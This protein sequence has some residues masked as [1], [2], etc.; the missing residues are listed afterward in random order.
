MNTRSATEFHLSLVAWE[1][2][3][4]LTWSAKTLGGCKSREQQVWSFFRWWANSLEIPLVKLP[5]VL[6]WERGEIGERPHA[7]FLLT[8]TGRVNIGE[9]FYRMS[10]WGEA[11]GH[12]KVRLYHEGHKLSGYTVKDLDCPRESW[13]HANVYELRKFDYA[14]RVCINDAAWRLML[15]A[16]GADYVPAHRTL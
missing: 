14:D 9:C 5:I 11:Y 10:E 7:H 3:G 16:V 12:A 8:G 1:F 2:F 6:R 15:S 13:S 4:S